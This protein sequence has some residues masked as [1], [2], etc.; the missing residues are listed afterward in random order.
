MSTLNTCCGYA[1]RPILIRSTITFTII[2]N[3][4]DEI[5]TLLVTLFNILSVHRSVD[6]VF[7]RLLELANHRQEQHAQWKAFNDHEPYTLDV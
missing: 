5:S 3:L 4:S 7:C 2:S 1:I 6:R